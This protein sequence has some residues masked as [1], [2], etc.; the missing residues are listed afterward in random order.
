MKTRTYAHSIYGLLL[1]ALVLGACGP[2]K[3]QWTP[4]DSEEGSGGWVDWDGEDGWSGSLAERSRLS[5]DVGEAP[6]MGAPLEEG[7]FDDSAT[8]AEGKET[9]QIANL[10]AGSVDDNAEWDDYLL[11]R[12]RF[13]DWGIHVHDVDVS[14]RHII[15]VSNAQGQP[16]LGAMVTI[17]D[18]GGD[19]VAVMHT[20]SDGRALFFPNA[21]KYQGSQRFE[22]RVEK[23]D[24]ETTFAFNRQQREHSITL[25]AQ[26]AS[27]PVRLDVLFLIDATGSMS[28]E[29]KQLKDNMITVSER[30]D[31]LPS[32]PNVR[33]GMTIYRDRGDLFVSRTY[34]FNPDVQAFIDELSQVLADGGGDY[35]ESLNEGL[36]NAIHLPEWRVEE[37][38]SLI[39][40]VADA[41]PHL[42]YDNDYDYA[43]EAF[44]AVERGIKIFPLAS[45]GLDDQGEYIFRQLA[46][47]SAGKFLFLTYGAGGAPGDDT[48][49]H[50]DDYS[51]L[52]LDELVVRIVEEELANLSFAQ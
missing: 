7:T 17:L 40:L 26:S 37:T 8:Y 33:F 13:A 24:A 51:V 15:Q 36:H 16:V 47:I 39:F 44:E 10:R 22:V 35:P 27:D 29:I 2:Y 30:I 41:P 25:N 20:H 28:D 52:S 48:T 4:T 14:E 42:D 50:V 21:Y 34:D 31:A 32:S 46:Q 5:E 6:A 12:L 23:D 9:N 1:V 43:H 19:E 38:V 18:E 45:S 11:Y 3:F 49:H